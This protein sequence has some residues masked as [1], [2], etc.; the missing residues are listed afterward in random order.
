[1]RRSC[2]FSFSCAATASDS[3]DACGLSIMFIAGNI[4]RVFAGAA[5]DSYGSTVSGF[6]LTI[7]VRAGQRCRSRAIYRTR[8]IR[9]K[10]AR[11]CPS[12]AVLDR[13]AAPSAKVLI[14]ERSQGN[15]RALPNCRNCDCRVLRRRMRRTAE[16][17][18]PN[19]TS[20]EP[21]PEWPPRPDCVTDNFASKHIEVTPKPQ[22]ILVGNHSTIF[23]FFG[24]LRPKCDRITEGGRSLHVRRLHMGQVLQIRGI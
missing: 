7:L 20:R 9:P 12:V 4:P 15:G 10:R 14:H 8:A 16:R 5:F 23:L 1:M 21:N 24:E 13:W 11:Q 22:R 2:S 18:Q 6:D 17:D 3:G 19:T